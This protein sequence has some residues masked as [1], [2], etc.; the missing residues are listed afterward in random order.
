MRE[1]QMRAQQGH[2]APALLD[3]AERARI[4][5]AARKVRHCARQRGPLVLYCTAIVFTE[6]NDALFCV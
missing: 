3:P 6:L 2:A 1:A 5:E 4:I